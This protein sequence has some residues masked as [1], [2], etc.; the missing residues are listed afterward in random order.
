MK[1]AQI[2]ID[3]ELRCAKC[4]G[5]NFLDKRTGRAHIVGFVTVGVGALATKKKLKC[6]SCGTMNDTGSTDRYKGGGKNGNPMKARP[7]QSALQ[8]QARIAAKE[9]AVVAKAERLADKAERIAAKEL[10]KQAK[11]A[12]QAA[13][14]L[15]KAVR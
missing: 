3:G 5:T 11:Q 14:E 10:K 6:Q 9:A 7:T 8:K 1:N 2:D 15:K 13:K 12:K 4:G